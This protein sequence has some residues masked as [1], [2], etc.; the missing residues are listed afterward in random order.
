MVLFEIKRSRMRRLSSLVVLV[1]TFSMI[2]SSS[3]FAQ[4]PEQRK[5]L[6]EM[7]REL[8]KVRG[9]IR[10]KE[11]DEAEEALKTSADRVREIAKEAELE[12]TDRKMLGL[13]PLIDDRL[14]DLEIARA[15]EEGRPPRLGPSFVSE[16]APIIEGKCV[17]CHGG[18]NPRKGLD[19]S[20]FNGW[21][22]G[23][24]SG[25]LLS[26]GK[27]EK[28][29]LMA[30]V[31]TTERG[32]MPPT[33]DQLSQEEL[34][35]L[36]KW[37]TEGATF[38]GDDKAKMLAD[39]GKPDMPEVTVVIPAPKGNETVSFT[40]DI[41]PFMAN[42]CVG[43]HSGN[44]PNGGLSLVSFHDM[45]KGGDS[46]RV[47]IPGNRDGSRLFRLTGGLENPRMPQGQARITRKNYEDLKKW[48]EE[49]NTFDGT[50]PK[51]PLRSFVKSEAEMAA[52]EFAMKT[53]EEMN[54]LRI[55]LTEAQ[56]KKVAPTDSF[57]TIQSDDLYI[58]GNVSANRLEEVDG[59]ANDQITALRKLFNQPNGQLWKGRLAVF[60]LKDR[61][62]YD[63]FNQVINGRRAQ[64]EMTGHS[65]VTPNYEEAYIVLQ[66]IGDEATEESGGLKV[67]LIDHLT[68][69][70][71]RRDGATMPEWVLRG[72]GLALAASS[73]DDNEFLKTMLTTA[74]SVARTVPS[75]EDV[76]SDGT[77]SP[78]T[79]GPVG[80]SVV[81][82]MI[83]EGGSAKFVRFIAAIKG[84]SNTAQAVRAVY[85]ADL[86]ALATGYLNS[87]E[88][89][90]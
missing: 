21:L 22:K 78:A 10:K 64:K 41:A 88:G 50:D 4:T 75:P 53:P 85:N 24:E 1:L 19:L 30:R 3:L 82:Y 58:I 7:K 29:L 18:D 42:L 23:G 8:G 90:R 49:G 2:I 43:C 70:Y 76:F 63:E 16:V 71:L 87:L 45:M 66:D 65:V 89:R 86:R 83:A 17:R 20:T 11:F 13:A 59:W 54:K 6:L 27:P 14:R 26:V 56:W 48:F 38:D 55:D 52:E 84:G 25:R 32:R 67:N 35:I 36:A 31:A 72:T 81:R 40:R 15:K 46:G 74:R 73:A 5:E 60:V 68:G 77:F 80:Y 44:D 34:N 39:L 61:F 37:I 62:N 57:R 33:G 47:I 69:A 28:S 51:A 12:P 79:I 9:M